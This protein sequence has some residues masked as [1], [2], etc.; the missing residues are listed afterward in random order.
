MK[1]VLVISVSLV[2]FKII[3]RMLQG[4]YDVSLSS[5]Y[6]SDK[7]S[8]YDIILMDNLFFK[9]DMLPSDKKVVVMFDNLSDDVNYIVHNGGSYIVKP[10]TKETLMSRI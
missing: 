6:N 8:E 9:R 7:V 10:F 3:E 1:R 2:R 4:E 5:E